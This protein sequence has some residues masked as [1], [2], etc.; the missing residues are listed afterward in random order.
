VSGGG[1]VVLVLRGA[2]EIGNGRLAGARAEVQDRLM[3]NGETGGKGRA[4]TIN[5]PGLV[6]RLALPRPYRTCN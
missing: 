4:G 1:T 2:M 5:V 3:A 6:R